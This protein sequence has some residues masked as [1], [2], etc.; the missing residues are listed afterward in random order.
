MKEFNSLCERQHLADI[1]D[2]LQ[3]LG[4]AMLAEIL[5]I[6]EDNLLDTDIEL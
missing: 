5:S 4:T 1:E 3:Q 2:I 6:S